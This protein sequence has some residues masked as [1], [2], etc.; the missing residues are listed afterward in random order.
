LVADVKFCG[1]TR[2]EDAM[3]AADLSAAFVG[4][5]FATSPRQLTVPRARE[6]LAPIRGRGTGTVGVFDTVDLDE[7]AQTAERLELDAVQLHGDADASRIESLRRRFGGEIWAVLRIGPNGFPP[8]AAELFGAADGV[9]LDTLSTRGRG[10]TGESFAWLAVA[11]ELAELRGTTRVVVAG[12]LRPDNVARA[13]DALAPDV[14]DVSSGV[15]SAAG[16]KDPTHLRAFMDAVR[17]HV[18]R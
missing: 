17:N 18:P 16:I 15:E 10:G 6:V 13:I 1:M 5:I 11:T 8:K 12:G 14:V 7:I 4:V 9:V 2:P 3:L